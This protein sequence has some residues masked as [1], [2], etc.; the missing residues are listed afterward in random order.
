MQNSGLRLSDT[1]CTPP[2]GPK[3]AMLLDGWVTTTDLLILNMHQKYKLL[4][5][6]YVKSSI[7]R[8]IHDMQLEPQ[9]D[10]KF[11]PNLTYSKVLCQINDV[12]NSKIHG[13][14]LVIV[15]L[16]CPVSKFKG[17]KIIFYSLQAHKVKTIAETSH[18][19]Y[20]NGNLSKKHYFVEIK[21]YI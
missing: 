3:F 11:A 5:F 18:G 4:S 1:I 6:R 19:S 20:F 8:I 13:V 10:F 7:Q 2:L 12:F 17:L 15:I 21:I 9:I 14:F 16:C